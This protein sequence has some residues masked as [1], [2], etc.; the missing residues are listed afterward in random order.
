MWKTAT[1][2]CWRA[3]RREICYLVEELLLGMKMISSCKATILHVSERE[4]LKSFSR[5]RSS[6]WGPAGRSAEPSGGG[7]AESTFLAVIIL[8]KVTGVMRGNIGAVLNRGNN[9]SELQDRFCS[10]R[11]MKKSLHPIFKLIVARSERLN[12]SS[13][14]FRSE[15]SR[16]R[17]N[18]S[19]LRLRVGLGV[20]LVVVVVV[21][22][23]I[24]TL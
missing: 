9:L 14:L 20:G 4:Q 10:C 7:G 17:R 22:I 23:I 5:S 13:D 16:L 1:T 3:K 6:S 24:S 12:T 19:D 21:I 15:A 11:N 18:A 8:L 2:P